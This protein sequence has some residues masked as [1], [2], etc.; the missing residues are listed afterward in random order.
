[1]S[2]A[3]TQELMRTM[4]ELM[5]L[6]GSV[7]AKTTKLNEA[8]PQTEK[9]LQTFKQLERVSLRYLAISRR[10]GLPDDAEKVIQVVTKLIIIIEMARMSLRLLAGGVATTPGGIA[11]AIASGAAGLIM[12]GLSAGS[13]LEGY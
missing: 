11:I 5:T 1:M 2:L 10:M 3:E 6:L 8:A 7:E 12:A 13:A 9:T 4:Q